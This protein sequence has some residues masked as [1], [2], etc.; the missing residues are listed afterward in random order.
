[1]GLDLDRGRRGRRGRQLRVERR[2]DAVRALR[3]EGRRRVEQPEIARMRHLGDAG[4]ELA[5]GPGQQPVQ[6]LRPGEIELGQL[7]LEA[8][9]VEGRGDRTLRDAVGGGEQRLRQP[10]FVPASRSR[11]PG[12]SGERRAPRCGTTEA[13]PSAMKGPGRL[14]VGR[15]SAAARRPAK[16][17]V[18]S[19]R[20]A[21]S[22]VDAD[23]SAS[24]RKAGSPRRATARSIAGRRSRQEILRAGPSRAAAPPVRG[25]PS[26]RLPPHR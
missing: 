3:R 23:R 13:E 20:P 22:A 10:V 26:A 11:R 8:I 7:P 25:S 2:G 19:T 9:E 24:W 21:P 1:M 16:P 18:R 5:D 6:R 15:F 12:N 4:L 17:V 14:C